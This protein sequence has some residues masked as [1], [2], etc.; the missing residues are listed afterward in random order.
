MTCIKLDDALAAVSKIIRI[1]DCDYRLNCVAYSNP[2]DACEEAIRALPTVEAPATE[3]GA[4]LQEAAAICRGIPHEGQYVHYPNYHR[5]RDACFHQSST[6]VEVGNAHADAIL[7]LNINALAAL[8][9]AKAEAVKRAFRMTASA[10]NGLE[11]GWHD[12]ISGDYHKLSPEGMRLSASDAIRALSSDPEA[13]RKAV[14][15]QP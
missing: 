1:G 2:L 12:G 8:Q 10:I 4:V 15:G 13:I 5:L 7:A 11:T 14:E 3:I 6:E 9:E